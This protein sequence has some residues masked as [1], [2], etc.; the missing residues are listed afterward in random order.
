MLITMLFGIGDLDDAIESTAP[1]LNLFMNTGSIGVALLLSIV[2][3]LLCFSGNVTSLATASREVWAFSRDQGLPGSR[4]LS[5]LDKKRS[6]PS[7]AVYFA[8]V[9]CAIFCLIQLG[10]TL[11][12]NIIVSLSVLG[13][14][15]T[16]MISIGCV[17]L[18]RIKGEELPPARWSLGRLG[19]P[20]NLVAF[21]YS[22]FVLIWCCFP[23]SL[24]VDASSANWAPLVWAAVIVIS[25]V[26]YIVHGKKHFTAPVM[27]VEGR[28]AV[29][30]ELQHT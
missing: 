17:L 10:S 4:W 18:K 25:L 5:H 24:P 12:F 14:L 3:F 29:G 27:Y 1:Y 23:I 11:A 15:S 30:T 28:R 16:Y 21:V 13:L 19:L 6:V 2:L 7:N 22:A 9:V 8:S 26:V 20:V